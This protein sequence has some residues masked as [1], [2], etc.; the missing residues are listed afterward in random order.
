VLDLWML[1]KTS[2]PYSVESGM[3]CA[4]WWSQRPSPW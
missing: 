1:I 3:V 4:H 2:G